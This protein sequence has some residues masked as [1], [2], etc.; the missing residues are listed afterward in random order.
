MMIRSRFS[1]TLPLRSVLLGQVAAVALLAAGGAVAQT[2]PAT[3]FQQYN[4][5]NAASI[6]PGLFSLFSVPVDTLEPTQLNVGDSEVEKKTADWNLLTQSQLQS[7]L[8]GDVETVVIGPGGVLYQTNGHHTFLSLEDSKFGASNPNVFVN[9]VANFSNDTPQQFLADLQKN[10]L[11]YPV[12]NGVVQPV[13]PVAGPGGTV[14]LPPLPTTLTG[15]TNDPDRGLEFSVLK[16]KLPGGAGAGFDKTSG[17]Y[18]DFI[19]ANAYR[20]AVTATGTG[21]AFASP[22]DVNNAAKFS[23][24]AANMTNLPGVGPISVGQLPGFILSSGIT[25]NGTISDA[26]L[27]GGALDGTKT[28]TFSSAS[29]ASFNGLNGLTLG[30][31]VVEQRLPGFVMQLGADSGNTVTLNGNNT[32]H[33]G[34]TILAGTLV[35][36]SDAALGAAPTGGAIDPNN[37]AASVEAN[38]GIIFNSL[39][40]GNGTLRF[41]PTSGTTFTTARDIAIGSE[42]AILDPDGNTVTLTGQLASFNLGEGGVAPLT[43]NDSTG[44]GTVILAP[45]S[46]S[47][48][49]F[50][51]NIVISAGTLEAASDA[52]LGNNAGPAF[53]IG[54]IDLDGGTFK[55]GGNISSQRSVFLTGSSTLDTNGFN[56]TFGALQDVQRTLTVV[57]SGTTAGSVGFQSL[58]I[59]ATATL[60]VQAGT[61]PGATT[62]VTLANGIIRDGNATLFLDPASG[63][64]GTVERVFSSGA[65]T[66]LT[67]GIVAPWIIIDSGKAASTSPYDFATYGANGYTVATYSPNSITAS[68]ATDVV[69]QSGAVTLT[70]NAQAFAL[71]LQS[72]AAINL[73]ANTLTLGDGVDPAGLIMTSSSLT[74]GKLAFG[75]SEAVVSL[76]GSNTISSTLVGTGGLT[77]AGSGSLT[78]STVTQETGAVTID[79]GT[80]TLTAQNALAGSSGVTLEDVKKTPAPAILALTATNTFTALNSAGNNSTVQL[81][82]GAALIVGDANNQSSTLSSAITETGAAVSGATQGALTKNGTGLLDLSNESKGALSLVAGSDVVV[83]GGQLRVAANIFK[84][85]N[86]IVLNNGSELQLVQGG[87]GAFANN[88]TGNGDLHLM[89]GTLQLTGTGNSYSGGTILE[90]GAVLDATT[91]NLSSTNANITNAGGVLVLD[92]TTSGTYAGV[93]SDGQAAGVGPLLSGSLVKDD[94]SGANGGNVTIAQQQNFT[95]S[96]SVEA[97]TLTLAAKDTLIN[98]SGVDLGRLG[99]GGV[100]TLAIGA[101]NTLQALSTEQNNTAA[102]QLNG[103]TLTVN[104]TIQN[105]AQLN[106][107]NTS[108]T[109]N[110]NVAN[111]GTVQVGNSA[112]AFAGTF[113]N[114]GT[115]VTDASTTSFGTLVNS[116]SGGLQAA[117]GAGFKIS[118]DFLNDA[119]N[120]GLSNL[121]GAAFSFTTGTG[122]TPTAHIFALAGLDLAQSNEALIG[123]F[124]IGS[125][126]ITGQTLTLENG[127]SQGQAA[128]YVDDIAGAVIDP[129]VTVDGLELIDNINGDG[130]NIYYNPLDDQAL[131]GLDYALVGGGELIADVPEPG[132][133]LIIIPGLGAG[134][135]M[136][137]RR[138]RKFADVA[139][140]I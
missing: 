39:S 27:A 11:I 82:N 87:G 22:S 113:T 6:Q 106:L 107:A 49:L 72:G 95:G 68:A 126:D 50:F 80:L 55:A 96:T 97:G 31:N 53:A 140:I 119:A 129:T 32:Y 90:V 83:N 93:M 24:N 21:L 37:V 78:L 124:L 99:G 103:H 59:G 81:S 63:T 14:T 2:L 38:N 76:K 54:Q 71:N 5:A 74:G 92:Q 34:T 65:S 36:G 137:R 20:N 10:G 121:S 127:R 117:T 48:S 115:F 135:F 73:G 120:G 66:T 69:K 62:T 102:L 130:F 28:G 85:A 75:G 100:A 67:N 116:A 17:A 94:S 84:T 47:N 86:T 45:T 43:I 12:N 40:E 29:S 26:T 42:T 132:S 111:N 56:S 88:V 25:I 131:G 105:A 98:S 9:V 91:A 70:K 58:E 112:V 1:R 35:V 52:A 136:M 118:G 57:N 33:G 18:S 101:D 123:D 79:S 139:Q 41:A 23:Q 60:A 16:N 3:A 128:L 108:G 7:T 110:A 19:W 4:A 133:W 61:T 138:S 109:I 46:G 15:L 64:L 51:G 114:N 44:K 8:L 122:A 104:S 134:F 30:P 77:L 125:L 13:T 89:S